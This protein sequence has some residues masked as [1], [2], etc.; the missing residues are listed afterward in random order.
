[1]KSSRIKFAAIFIIV[2]FFNPFSAILPDGHHKM[3]EKVSLATMSG[4]YT[5]MEKYLNMCSD[6][7]ARDSNGLTPLIWAAVKG[8]ARAVQIL[9]QR[10]ADVNAAN[11][12]GDSALMWASVMGHEHV[13]EL[14]L[15]NN[16]DIDFKSKEN[17]VTALMAAAAKGH[18]DVVRLLLSAGADANSKDRNHNTA[19]MHATIKRYPEVV[20]A[21]LSAGATYMG[22]R[23]SSTLSAWVFLSPRG[24]LQ[25]IE[26]RY[27][28]GPG[29]QDSRDVTDA[30]LWL[31]PHD[32]PLCPVGEI[33]SCRFDRAE[34][35]K[36]S[37][38]DSQER[39]RF[40]L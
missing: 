4:N 25:G 2:L 17:G 7:N 36:S 5:Q 24:E 18:A 20:N 38:G 21:L 34:D 39:E 27:M 37:Y 33:L 19:L 13:V 1:M 30:Y 40:T 16:P 8:N 9:L 35:R 29:T 14:L 31:S 10:G 22:S 26:L 32:S 12:Q 11:V 28:G 3:I 23:P 6:I 15:E